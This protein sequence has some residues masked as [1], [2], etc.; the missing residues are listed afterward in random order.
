[1][2]SPGKDR[3]RVLFVTALAV[4]LV[5][6]AVYLKSSSVFPLSN[7][8]PVVKIWVDPDRGFDS[9]AKITPVVFLP[10]LVLIA[11][12]LSIGERGIWEFLNN[13]VP[14]LKAYLAPP[15]WLR[16]PPTL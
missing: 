9:K 6:I 2:V 10:S 14:S 8:S 7:A 13:R 11:L 16:P 3:L 12:A 1:M 4:F 15:V 5:F